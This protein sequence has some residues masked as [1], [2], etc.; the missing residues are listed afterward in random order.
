MKLEKTYSDIII[1]TPNHVIAMF[2]LQVMCSFGI[3]G[4][5]EIINTRRT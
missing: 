2:Y 1:Q 3:N 4:N 5:D